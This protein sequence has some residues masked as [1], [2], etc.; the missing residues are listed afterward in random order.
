MRHHNK[1]MKLNKTASHRRAMLRNLLTAL[2]E[3]GAIITTKPKSKLVK[4][5]ADRMIILGKKGDLHSRRLA[6][7]YLFGRSALQELFDRWAP[8]MEGTDSGFTR[9]VNYKIRKGDGAQLTLIHLIGAINEDLEDLEEVKAD[10]SE[11]EEE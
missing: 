2:F 1:L 3:H 11:P 9:T 10:D 4:K 5:W 7:R 8:S 6:A